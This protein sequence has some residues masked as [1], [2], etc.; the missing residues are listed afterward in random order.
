MPER[1]SDGKG[2]ISL[3]AIDEPAA[4]DAQAEARGVRVVVAH[5][6]AS[7]LDD[8][9]L[10]A[11]PTEEERS[12]SSGPSRRTDPESTERAGLIVALPAPFLVRVGTRP[13]FALTPPVCWLGAPVAQWI[14]H[15]TT[16]Q[17]VGGSILPAR[18]SEA[19]SR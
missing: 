19:L 3:E 9:V 15:L 17:K 18:W 11:K 13:W 12:S 6:L 16:D 14:E 4:A 7:T 10:D 2:G 5:E 1:T 8:A